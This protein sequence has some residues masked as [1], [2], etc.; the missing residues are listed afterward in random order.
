MI[1]LSHG[2]E[3]VCSFEHRAI[4]CGISTHLRRIQYQY[5]P[6]VSMSMKWLC[7]KLFKIKIVLLP[8][9][10]SIAVPRFLANRP[11]RTVSL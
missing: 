2:E 4:T 5:R 1:D 8:A 6:L 11:P 7:S 3:C 10:V 9:S